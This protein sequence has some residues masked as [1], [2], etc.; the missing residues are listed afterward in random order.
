MC[1]RIKNFCLVFGLMFMINNASCDHI[2]DQWPTFDF[3]PSNPF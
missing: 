2:I 3:M 1:K